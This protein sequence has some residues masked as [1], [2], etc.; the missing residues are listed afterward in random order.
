MTEEYEYR[1]SIWTNGDWEDR[2]LGDNLD[3]A[4]AW[5]FMYD[6]DRYT[7]RAERRR[8]G[9]WENVQD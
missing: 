8:V 1:V 7:A 4:L 9:P 2:Y 6:P 3:D 5:Y